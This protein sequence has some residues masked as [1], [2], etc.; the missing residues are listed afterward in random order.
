MSYKVKEV[1]TM[2]GVSVR[3]LHH[4]DSIGLLE[5]ESVSPA[6]YRL[7][8]E[9]DLERL[10]QILF[11]KELD[12]S[13]EEIKSIIHSPGFDRLKALQTHKALLL[14]KK[15]R[16]EN[17][18]QAVEKTIHASKGGKS[19]D[20]KA[21]FHAFDMSEIEK[22][23]ERYAEEARQ[24]YGHT[25]AYKESQ[26]RTSRYTKEDWARIMQRSDE[27]HSRLAALMDKEPSHPEVQEAI[28]QWRQHI[29]DSFYDCTPEIFRGLGDLYV[30]D[31]RFTA[32]IDRVKP[33]LAGFMREAMFIYC[34]NL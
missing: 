27:I 5:P 10:Q 29:T 6:G 24:K 20:K 21:M 22:H 31:E 4:Y 12:F 11:F 9:K 26:K 34:D 13:L 14:M 2:A 32:N 19:M 33:G 8:T 25:D 28:G 3:T 23:Q 1:A 30:S 18:I 17:I 16:L 15:Q 7:Y